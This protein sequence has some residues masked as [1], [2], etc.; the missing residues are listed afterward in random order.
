MLWLLITSAALHL[1]FLAWLARQ[2]QRDRTPADPELWPPIS[3][4]IAARNESQNLQA[5]LPGILALPYPGETEIIL[6]LNNTT[7][8]SLRSI[9][10]LI[11]GGSKLRILEIPLTPPGWSPKKH[12]LTQAIDAAKYPNLLFTDADCRPE[13]QW[14][15]AAGRAFASGADLLIGHSPYR[16]G[17]GLLNALVRHET[18]QT[19]LLYTGFAR[20]GR[21]YMAVGRN[22]GYTRAFFE[23]AGRFD[24]HKNRLS[25]DDDLLV[26]QHGRSAR[27][28]ILTQSESKVESDA[29][30]TWK[31]WFRQKIRHLSAGSAYSRSSM[32]I[33]TGFHGLHAIFYLSLILVLCGANGAVLGGIAFLARTILAMAV[34]A[35]PAQRWKNNVPIL[36]FPLL[37]PLFLLY[38]FTLVPLS[39]VLKPK[40]K[41]N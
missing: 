5:N 33:L 10:L 2:W 27:T 26:N 20:V 6:A 12:A 25:G 16:K 29:P 18:F 34:L 32:L 22:I 21:P 31:G 36:L 41:S 9:R 23:S 17:P 14:L 39:S 3:I 30:E 1:L 35:I 38:Q 28:A 40:W 8:D 4:V 19:A 7:D 15:L 11:P 24:A 13:A 37:D